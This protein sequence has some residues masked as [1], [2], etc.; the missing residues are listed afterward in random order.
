MPDDVRI[1]PGSDFPFEIE[2][3]PHT[4][5]VLNDGTRLAARLWRPIT[6]DPVPLILEYLPYRKGDLTSGRDEGYASWFAGH[7]YAYARI[8]IRGTGDS[9][10]IITDEYAPQE[11]D[12]ALEVIA[13]LADR[14]WCSGAVG[15]I[16]I[17]WGGF[18]G[19]QIAARRPPAL[20]AVISLCSTDD[21][22]ADDVHY[23]G[24]CVLAWDMLPWHAVMF[25]MDALPPDP[26]TVGA[27]WRDTWL[28]RLEET[29]PFD[30]AWLGHQRRDDYWRHGS[31]CEDFGAIEAPVWMV[32]GWADGYTNAIGRT[33]AGLPGPRK[34]LIGPWPHAFPHNADQG[35]R[36][37]FLQ[38]ALRWWD[39]WLRDTPTGIDEEPTVQAWIQEPARPEDLALDRPGRWV[40]EDA[41]PPPTVRPT[42]LHLTA[43]HGLDGEPGGDG[44]LSHL[45]LQRHGLFAGTWCPYGPAADLPP[46]QREDDAL[47]LAFDSA[48]LP[49]RIELLGH[50]V[51]HLRVA[52]DRPSAFVLA[53]LCAVSPDGTSMLLSRGALNLTHRR[54]HADPAPL[55]PGEPVDVDIEMDVLG[56][57]IAAGDRLRL[58]LSPT[59]WPWL[60]PSPEPVT[61]T[62]S[63]GTASWLELPTRPLKAPDGDVRTFAQPEQGARPTGLEVDEVDAFHVIERDVVTGEIALRM[64]QDGDVT[65]RFADGL[66][67][68]ERN[69]DRYAIVEGDPLSAVV[70]AQ[71]VLRYERD[72]VR[73]RIETRSRMTADASDFRL[74]DTLE[75]YENDLQVFART[76]DRRIPRDL[77]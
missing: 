57:A 47:A 54:S 26:A 18:N 44:E 10:G 61:L 64:N 27:G 4:W 56:Q 1:V 29:P 22:Y 42:R 66:L 3:T 2:R 35:P 11:Q 5:I 77:V 19:L 16:G 12:D 9:D 8:D 72:D 55:T 69:R 14:Q 30:D 34:A 49:E 75:A 36:I 43:T 48:P 51:V 6:D 63:A 32:G 33:V 25:A 21:R 7:G 37:G 52:A 62:V 70:E 39:R 45:G 58:T 40:A 15:M 46:D 76:W 60:W 24:G 17:S 67:F 13:W 50:P 20:R 53:R 59:Y 74:E 71:R 23:K 28:R 73:V 31:V 68:D 41:W 65:M 38:E